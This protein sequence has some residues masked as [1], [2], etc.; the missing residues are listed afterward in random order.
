MHGLT[1]SPSISLAV[2]RRHW[3]Q[4]YIHFISPLVA[5]ISQLAAAVLC[6]MPYA[7]PYLL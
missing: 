4:F 1:G 5:C 6:I 2:I 7:L 3:L